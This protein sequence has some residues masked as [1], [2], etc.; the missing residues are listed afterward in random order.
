MLRPCK[1]TGL[2]AAL[3]V[4]GLSNIGPLGAQTT[5]EAS[6]AALTLRFGV[7]T[8]DKPSEML[9]MFRGVRGAIEEGLERALRRDVVVEMKIYKDYDLAIDALAEGDCD[10]TRFGPASYILSKHRNDGVRLLAMEHKQGEKRFDGLIITRTDSDIRSLADLRGRSFAFGNENSTIGRYLA[11]DQLVAAGVRA[12]DLARFDY[13]GR[14][15]AV[16][17][18]V[19]IGDFDAGSLKESTYAKMNKRGEL[20]VVASFENVTKP[21]VARAGLPDDVHA[22]VRDAL[23]AIDDEDVLSPLKISGFFPCDDDEYEFVRDGMTR[24]VHFDDL[25]GTSAED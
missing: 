1:T 4:A 7:Y 14:H 5:A 16:A 25:P 11:Q 10:F 15:D 23:L 12:S 22:A 3:A 18:A 2:L 20:R 21:W 19:E 6:S 17:K 8:S 13:L 24:S 9:K